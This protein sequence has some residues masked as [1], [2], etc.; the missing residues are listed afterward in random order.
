MSQDVG[1]PAVTSTYPT[2][3]I[4]SIE[5]PSLNRSN[6]PG[7]VSMCSCTTSV[8]RGRRS[9]G[10]ARAAHLVH[11]T[12]QVPPTFGNVA[13]TFHMT[14]APTVKFP[15]IDIE[16]SRVLTPA[17]PSAFPVPSRHRAPAGRHE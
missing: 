9:D 15:G 7:P 4:G 10:R 2:S 1:A 16:L 3:E 13:P 17:R 6:C 14:E 12:P 11:D 5:V 8:W